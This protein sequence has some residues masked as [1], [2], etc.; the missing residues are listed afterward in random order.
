MHDES[1]KT[2]CLRSKQIKELVNKF[3]TSKNSAFSCTEQA[4]QAGQFDIISPQ[5]LK[6][7]RIDTEHKLK[8]LLKARSKVTLRIKLAEQM[9]KRIGSNLSNNLIS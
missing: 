1:S 8:F 4:L 9:L 2:D 5:D 3:N 7:K 6:P